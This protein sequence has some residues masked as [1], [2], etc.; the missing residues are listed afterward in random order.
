MLY[1][2]VDGLT[3][4]AHVP[5]CGHIQTVQIDR[6]FVPLG[7]TSATPRTLTPE[8]KGAGRS[9]PPCEQHLPAAPPSPHHQ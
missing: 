7:A 1:V 5:L 9:V 8:A 2:V 4:A 6:S 3:D